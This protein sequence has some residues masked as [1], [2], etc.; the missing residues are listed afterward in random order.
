MAEPSAT[1]RTARR[2]SAGLDVHGLDGR[3]LQHIAAPAAPTEDA[4]PALFNN[5]DIVHGFE[6]GG[7]K[8]A[9]VLSFY[10]GWAVRAVTD[11]LKRT[12]LLLATADDVKDV[13]ARTGPPAESHPGGAL[14]EG[15][16]G[17]R[18]SLVLPACAC[19]ELR[20]PWCR[21]A[22]AG[23]GTGPWS[24]RRHAAHRAPPLHGR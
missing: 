5:V 13:L 16:T 4:K 21:T 12:A 9:P 23:T 11:D 6:L 7:Q 20:L 24:S 19:K 1:R 15:R 8:V 10:A 2:I 14:L 17:A 18:Q 22:R 3:R